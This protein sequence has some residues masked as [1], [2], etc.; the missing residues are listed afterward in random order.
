MHVATRWASRWIVSALLLA[1]CDTSTPP[2]WNVRRAPASST[3]AAIAPAASSSA[4]VA[5]PLDRAR[6][7]EGKSEGEGK[8]AGESWG[9]AAIAW[10]TPDEGLAEAR[11]AN[12]PVMVVLYTSWCPHCRNFSQVFADPKVVEAS[13][14]FV[15]IRANSDEAEA[16][17]SKYAPDGNYIPRT[18]FLK[19]DGELRTDVVASGGRF[20]YFYDEKDSTPLLNAMA[21]ASNG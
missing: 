7:V 1:S 15:M 17:A 12:K 9:G 5:A 16:F 18:L 14:R 8:G 20:K 13:K 19:P 10:R 4:L 3:S 2:Q 11:R 21:K 6:A